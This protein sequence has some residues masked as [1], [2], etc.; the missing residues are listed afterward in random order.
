MWALDAV[1]GSAEERD[2]ATEVGA[3][4]AVFNPQPGTIP[5]SGGEPPGSRC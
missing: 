5:R 4:A 3:R 1:L 2:C